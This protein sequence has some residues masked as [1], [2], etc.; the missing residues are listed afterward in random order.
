M[1]T[2]II[3]LHKLSMPLSFLPGIP[4][5]HLLFPLMVF[6]RLPPF[7][8]IPYFFCSSDCIIS[9]NLSSRSLIVSPAYSCLLLKI[10][11]NLFSS[12]LYSSAANFLFCSCFF[13]QFY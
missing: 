4:I 5:I 10:S 1:G 7:L 8:F 11:S 12:V 9:V 3:S 2:P 13:F 6:H